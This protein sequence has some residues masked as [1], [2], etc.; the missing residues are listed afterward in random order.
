[1]QSIHKKLHKKRK[2]RPLKE[3]I[4][5]RY[6]LSYLQKAVMKTL[7]FLC[8]ISFGYEHAIGV[9]RIQKSYINKPSKAITGLYSYSQPINTQL[10]R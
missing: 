4:N 2:I 6:F 9:L 5:L 1:M 3:R 7:L 10:D 8:C